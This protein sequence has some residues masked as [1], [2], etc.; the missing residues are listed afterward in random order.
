MKLER[1]STL[2]FLARCC[3]SGEEVR[4]DHGPLLRLDHGDHSLEPAEALGPCSVTQA[5]ALS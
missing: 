3:G 2:P 4:S 5:H 1:L